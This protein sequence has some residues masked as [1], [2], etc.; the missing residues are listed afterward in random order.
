[1][2]GEPATAS[3]TLDGKAIDLGEPNQAGIYRRVR[4]EPGVPVPVEVSYPS[5][6]AGTE[7]VV[8]VQHGG[9]L[10]GGAPAEVLKL[11]ELR[12]ARFTYTV[13]GEPGLFHVTVR[14]GSDVKI[15][16][17]WAGPE[18]VVASQ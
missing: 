9:S 8:A 12:R 16:D 10:K 1:M 6:S 14:K 18:P 7:V 2:A 4:T 13:G 15:L 5:A 3:I 17:F 11:D